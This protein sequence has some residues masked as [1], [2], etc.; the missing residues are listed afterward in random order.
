MT[1]GEIT[2]MGSLAVAA[3]ALIVSLIRNGKHDSRQAAEAF[4][5]QRAANAETQTKLD[6]IRE[7]VDDIRVE[8]RA[9]RSRQDEMSERLAGAE[10]SIKSAHHRLDA[11]E[12][13][14]MH[15]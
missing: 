2:A 7:G 9:M 11:L 8:Q 3:I 14:M 6:S 10:S 15:E 5:A 12:G 4:A 1:P 13:R